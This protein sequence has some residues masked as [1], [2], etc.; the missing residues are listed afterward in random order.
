ML[1]RELIGRMPKAELHVHL[2]GSLRPET[3]IE[4]ARDAR[5]TLP[6]TDPEA[7]RRHMLVS[8][9]QN[10][11]DYLKR[12]D[13][14]VS[15][16]QTADAIER[17][18]YEM[19]E[20]GARD[21]LRYLEVRYCP[22]L[23]TH[24]GLT[25][26]AVVEAQHRGFVRGE[27]DFGVRTGIINCSLRHYP[28]D[29]SIEIAELSV[30]SKALGVVAFDLA[31]GEAG[32]PPGVHAAA[33]D[34][35]LAGNLGITVHAGEAYG[36]ASV[37]EAIRRCHAMRIGHGTRLRENPALQDF[38]RDRRILI[39]SNIT[40][41]VQTRVVGKP[42]EHPVRGYFDA[43]L[44]VTLCTDSW[45]MSGVYLSDEYWLAHRSLGF[46]RE[47]IHRMILNA[48]AAAFLPWPERQ[49]LLAGVQS[50]LEAM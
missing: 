19:V 47:E 6:S 34:V 27:R 35:A 4:L 39:E 44:A 36:P 23:S 24:G 41:N 26:E 13:I 43:G 30:R 25:M 10:L 18:A 40:S 7:L 28:P 45:L 48:F 14:T 22:H 12:F 3:M 5:V 46:T 11:G 38:V 37:S 32:F 16:L 1:T 21:N 50:E 15:L 29:R 9:A 33:F 31:G 2:D 42:E 17:V 20:D 49:A 8:D